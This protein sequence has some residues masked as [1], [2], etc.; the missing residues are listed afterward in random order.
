MALM[1]RNQSFGKAGEDP[2]CAG[3]LE[4]NPVI[5]TNALP[6]AQVALGRKLKCCT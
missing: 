2:R 4:V 6:A 5:Q 1:T 3:G